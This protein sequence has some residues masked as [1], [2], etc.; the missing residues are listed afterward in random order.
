VDARDGLQPTSTHS[1]DGES[2]R[3]ELRGLPCVGRDAELA[4][5]DHLWRDAERGGRVAL[6]VGAA[7]IG[8]SRLLDAAAAR[9]AGLG[10]RP[11]ATRCSGAPY[12]AIRDLIAG[13]TALLA[14]GE[15]RSGDGALAAR[16]REVLA[17][18]DGRFDAISAEAAPGTTWE[19]RR[20]ALFERAAAFV[21]DASRRRPLVLVIDDLHLAD[22]ATRALLAHLLGTRFGLPALDG[23][24]GDRG[25]GL[26][27]L[28]ARPTAQLDEGWLAGVDATRIALEPLGADGVRAFLQTPEVVAFFAEATG[29]R[30]A[31]LE[32]LLESRLPPADDLLAARVAALPD[33]ARALLDALAVLGRPESVEALAALAEVAPESLARAIEALVDARLVHRHVVD[34]ALRLSTTRPAIDEAALARLSP[35]ARQ[36]LEV[37]A[38]RML[39]ARA[40]D[41]PVDALVA[42]AEHLLRG[43]AGE[44]AVDVAVA[45]GERLEITFGYDRAIDLYRRAIA[46]T[47]REE[48]IA[49]L[50]VRLAELERLVGDFDAA[51]AHA[52]SSRRRRPDAAAHRR[53]AEVLVA[54]DE[55]ELALGE[56][57]AAE[58]RCGDDAAERGLVRAARAEALFLGGKLDEAAAEAQ[59]VLALPADSA[60]SRDRAIQVRNTLGKVALADG[61]YARAAALFDE[62]VGEARALGRA[63]EECRALFNSGI[64]RLR[65]GDAVEAQARYQA[66]LRVAD[67]AGDHR[68]RA[69]CL[70]NLGVLAHWRNDYA[71]A[72]STFQ[73]AVSA[74]KTIGQ[75]ARLAWLALDLASVFLDLNAVDRAEAMVRLALEFG[76]ARPPAAIL[77]DRD[78]LAGRVAARRGRFED[79]VRLLD[80]A[81]RAAE[82][83]A[84]RERAVD[85]ALHLVRAHLAA[86]DVPS[87]AAQV[88]RL[89]AVPLGSQRTRARALLVEGE[90]LHRNRRDDDARRLGLESA[91]I[92]RRVGDLEGEWRAQFLVGRAA[93]AQGDRAEA[94]RRYQSAAA[95]D[96]RVRERVPPEHRAAHADDPDRVALE[97]ALGVPRVVQFPAAAPSADGRPRLVAV[98]SPTTTATAAATATAPPDEL[99]ARYPRLVGRH[100]RLRQILTLIDKVAPS[101]SLVLIR[102]ES[103]TGKELVA[104]AIH[105]NSPRRDRPFVKVNCGA[106]VETLLLSELFGHE[107]GAFTGALQRK[108]GRFEAADGGTIFLD[109]IGD[110][111]PKTQVALLRVLQ[112][113]ELERVGGTTPVKIDVRILCATHRNLE[114]M[115]ARGE[116]REDLYYRLKGIQ[117]ELPSLRE[118]LDDLPLLA[119]AFLESAARERGVAPKRLSDGALALLR[120]HGWPGNVR[121]LENVIRSVSLFADGAVIEAADL[122]AYTEVFAR[123]AATERTPAIACTATTA[124]PASDEPG[125]DRDRA[126]ADTTPAAFRRL[127]TEGLSLKELKTRIEIEC[128]TEALARAGGNITRAAELLGMKRPRLSQLI[129]E[130]GLAVEPGSHSNDQGGR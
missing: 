103:G 127:S 125:R 12:D 33:E 129:K 88:V 19:L 23:A 69:Y 109:E 97:R 128:I 80:A 73:E 77:V 48:V 42:A 16:G 26:V 91:E 65:M 84:D 110:I 104:D 15:V 45:A 1:L 76:G 9:L 50:E 51:L 17:A 61:Q 126:G 40:G 46:V 10:A 36:T 3:R 34:G 75:R 52:E 24:R 64:A 112:E 120:R 4:A 107:R 93:A 41:A 116:F 70:Q 102:G 2:P 113:R 53:V 11:V 14:D 87:A 21:A 18:L 49:A 72:L 22:G 83:A 71:T 118:R 67:A 79:A 122:T 108:K 30:P 31:A 60:A 92:F 63:F 29:G 117:L 101:E 123:I 54:R 58:A 59:A 86:G 115:V 20:A 13:I 98:P 32:A 114:E 78:L 85:A 57:A 66:A 119:Q 7:G 44:E 111:S 43:G 56:L 55:I 90:L 25:A 38:G 99:L 27:L 39:L 74:F 62:N 130:H 28:G 6:V 124:A 37:R 95:L 35:A 47:A 105:A 94:T 81:A 89:R 8:K 96:R 121:E 106:L 68:N 82:A 100:P 5:I